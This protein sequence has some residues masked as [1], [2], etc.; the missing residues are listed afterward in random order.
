MFNKNTLKGM[1]KTHSWC[2]FSFVFLCSFLALSSS[3]PA[4][5]SLSRI[6]TVDRSDGKG[7]VIRYH[8]SEAV[9]SFEVIQPAPDLVQMV[10]YGDIDT[11]GI[12]MP[13]YGEKVNQVILYKQ[14]YGFGVD[15]YLSQDFSYI[16]DAYP[17]QN[18][19]HLLVGLTETDYNELDAYS[20]QFI[21]KN[22][23]ENFE[24]QEL[25]DPVSITETGST[26]TITDSYN[27]VRDK[28][29]FDKIVIDAGHGG[30]D[31]GNLGYK[32]SAQEKDVVLS[33]A[34]KLGKYIEENLPDVEVIYTR[35]TDEFVDLWERG[36]I[37]NRAEADLFVSIHAD[38]FTSSSVR[39][40]SVFFLGLDR[41][42]RSF[43][44][45]KEENQIYADHEVVQD[46]S[47]EDLI[48][49][50]LAHSGNIAN[51]ER[52][53]YM[54]EDQLKNRA[55]RKSR[56]VRQKGLVVLYQSTMPAI[57]VETGFLTN[58]AEKRYLT[59]DWGQSL[60]ASAIYRAIKQYKQE[61]DESYS[62]KAT[63]AND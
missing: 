18:Q 25:P 47:E 1:F 35:E 59:S 31:P 36:S 20:Q 4:Q 51:S 10:L 48:V 60:I 54:V 29:K 49:Y 46:L 34:K 23:Y 50:E 9:D 28:L 22:W 12:Q 15:I 53:A 58:P 27:P 55:Q 33:I 41:S 43:E 11:T 24:P 19:T 21:A 3:L 42:D 52:I 8:F 13:G 6:S 57:L 39:G 56:G 16:A 37:A 5:N 32:K 45:M 40:A 17:D 30:H 38:A 62:L 14:D 7:V 63:S 2:T 44:V 61:Q 26:T